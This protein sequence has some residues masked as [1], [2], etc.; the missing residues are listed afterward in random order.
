MEDNRARMAIL[1]SLRFGKPLVLDMMEV[2]MFQTVGDIFDRLM[3]GLLKSIM[4]KSILKNEKYA[5]H[6]LVDNC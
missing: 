1:G 2:D 6:K 3:K 5:S 4:D